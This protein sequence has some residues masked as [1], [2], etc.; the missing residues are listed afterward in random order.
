MEF[1]TNYFQ[2]YDAP[3]TNGV[4][5]FTF[6]A[7]DLAGNVTTFA[8]SVT[9][10]DSG[11]TNPPVVQLIWP[12][13]GMQIVGSNIVCRGQVSDQT[14]NVSVQLVDA[15]GT[16]NNAGSLVGRDGVFYSDNLTLPPGTNYLSYTMTDAKGN[17][18]N[19]SI[20][21]TTSDMGLTLDSVVAGQSV[22]TGTIDDTN[23]TVYVNGVQASLTNGS[24][25]A[26]IAPIGVSGG[27]VVVNAIQG[28][29]SLQQIVQPPQGVFVSKY[30]SFEQAFSPAVSATVTTYMDWEDGWGGQ[31]GDSMC[32]N[33]NLVGY[34]YHLLWPASSWPE[35][36][37]P[38]W[39]VIW[40]GNGSD[41]QS[42]WVNT[43]DPPNGYPPN[44]AQEHCERC[45]NFRQ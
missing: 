12:Q 27:A 43:N 30:H 17:F 45:H 22:V 24:W 33:T 8:A 25:T 26:Q 42:D 34:F 40:A 38:G 23:Y 4:N 7:T 29:P 35:P 10:D 5:S 37:P 28:G 20:T 13:D 14:V 32:G 11:K 36:L 18:T 41:N 3:L 44:L 19:V 15:N 21:V 16:T 1:A 6:H 2:C 31:S 9:L 39:V